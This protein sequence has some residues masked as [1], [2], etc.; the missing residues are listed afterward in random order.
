VYGASDVE[1]AVDLFDVNSAVH[2][3]ACASSFGHGTEGDIHV[4]VSPDVDGLMLLTCPFASGPFRV[5][6]AAFSPGFTLAVMT[7][8]RVTWPTKFRAP[9]IPLK[10]GQNWGFSRVGCGPKPVRFS[11]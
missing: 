8:G 10:S 6:I 11:I 4:R 9:D 2:F 1:N 5:A 7:V 3:E